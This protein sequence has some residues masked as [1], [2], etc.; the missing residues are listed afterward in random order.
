MLT[1]YLLSASIATPVIGRLGDM[2]GKARLLVAV[3]VVLCVATVLC[4]LATTLTVM[5]IGRVAQG[6]AGGIFPLAFGIMRDEFPRERVA[7]AVGTMSAL[8]ASAAGSA[9][10]WPARSSTTSPTTGCSGCRWSRWCIATSSMHLFVPE[11]PMR[12]PGKMNW[13]GALLMS[14]GLR[15]GAARRQRGAGLGVAVGQDH[16]RVRAGAV[17]L[18]VWVRSEAR[19]THPLVDMRMMRIRGVWTTNTVALLLGFGMYSSFILLPEYVETP[20]SAGYGFGA[21]GDRCRPVPRALDARDA[22]DGL[23]DRAARE[24]LRLQAAAAGRGAG[25]ASSYV[26]LALASGE[27]W[28]IYVAAL[29]L[30]AGIGLAFA[31]MVNL[32]IENVGPEQTGIAT[33]MN[34]VTRLDR[35]RVRRCG[36]RLDPGRERARQRL[37]VER[38]VHGGL[39]ALRGRAADRLRGRPRHPPAP[40]AGRVRPEPGAAGPVRLRTPGRAGNSAGASPGGPDL[41]SSRTPSRTRSHAMKVFVAGGSGAIGR[42]LVPLLVSVGHEVTATT[43]T[44]DGARLLHELGATPAVVDALDRE[45]VMV[46]VAAAEPEVVVNQ[47]TGLAGE[48]DLRSFDRAFAATN[49]LRIEGTAHL[50]EAARVSGVR[51]VVAQSFGNWN[52]ERAGRNLKH[53]SDPFD[54]HPPRSM[55]QSLAA[56]DQLE[57]TVLGADGVEGVALRYGNLYGPGAAIAEG[58]EMLELLR[59]QAAGDRERRRDLVVRARRRRRHGDAGGGRARRARRLQR[60]RRPP[61]AR[62]GLDPRARPDRRRRAAAPRAGLGRQARRRPCDRLDDDPHPRRLER[63]RTAR[64]RLEA[65]LPDVEGRLPRGPRR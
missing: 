50:V 19:S 25:D 3:L 28:E 59:P 8:P 9:S 54:A 13:T 62:A 6:A 46:A 56:I 21:L 30:G 43:R 53:E 35:R 65:A 44:Q 60:R 64:A 42:R 51:R 55:R 17:F 1:A 2:Y 12:V 32:I 61:G 22:R 4:A 40:A 24:A 26:L 58:G 15:P 47:L 18:V 36:G 34:T 49:R 31:S 7:G 16:R 48:L 20:S 41:P 11:S 57:A 23:P 10:S 38:R 63:P 14:L 29:L 33:G 27:R 37:P 5:L 39:R 52:Y 45:A